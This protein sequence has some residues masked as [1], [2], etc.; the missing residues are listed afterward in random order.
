MKIDAIGYQHGHGAQ[1]AVDRPEGSQGWLLLAVHTRSVFVIDGK[2]LHMPAKTVVIYAAGC[3]QHY[4]ADGESYVDDWMHFTPTAEEEARI[5]ALGLP[6]NMPI[7]LPEITAV[8]KCI[9]DMCAEYFSPNLMRDETVDLLFQIAL[10]KI[11]EGISEY[12]VSSHLNE[13]AYAGLLMWERSRIYRL[14][15]E[16]WSIDA[17]AAKLSL[18]RSRF[19]H[20][21]SETFGISF[22]RDI[23]LARLTRAKELL[24]ATEQ[25]V[26]QIA[27]AVGYG[28]VPHF[29]R[30]FKAAFG[31]TPSDYRKTYWAEQHDAT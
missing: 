12:S 20:I 1:F 18:S 17:L 25:S 27:A 10:N 14:P 3:P 6:L 28:N 8:S 22:A 26:G 29:N 23:I 5:R 16:N 13:G 24:T 31:K 21:Y 9:R 11:C 15:A 30:Q 2:P 19:Q 7:T 4:G